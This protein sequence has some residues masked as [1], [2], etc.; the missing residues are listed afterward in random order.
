MVLRWELLNCCQD[1]KLPSADFYCL[2][3][4][5]PFCKVD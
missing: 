4:K 2:V 5:M 3:E 1:K